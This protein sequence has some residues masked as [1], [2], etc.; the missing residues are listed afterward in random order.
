MSSRYGARYPMRRW[1]PI[2]KT[3]FRKKYHNRMAVD[4]MLPY[5]VPRGMPGG[6]LAR[7]PKGYQWAT[8]AYNE[9][10][11]ASPSG[12]STDGF[13]YRCNSM[14]DPRLA[15]GG[16]Q[17]QYFDQLTALYYNWVV[18]D[19]DIVVR[20]SPDNDYSNAGTS[21]FQNVYQAGVFIAPFK[22]TTGTVPSSAASDI[23]EWPGTQ[24]KPMNANGNASEVRLHIDIP[25]ML[26]ISRRAYIENPAF[27]GSATADLATNL[28]C[29]AWLGGMAMASGAPLSSQ[30]QA[31]ITYKAKFFSLL[32]LATS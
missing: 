5:S 13:V 9:Q 17:P 11:T 21:I 25:K 18:T 14:F 7:G 22:T 20:G 29:F 32:T 6:A 31:T 15:A 23:L 28:T 10:F 27:W 19:C 24:M 8:L 1:G 3:T 4:R 12:G 16:H 26:G 30:I 2:R